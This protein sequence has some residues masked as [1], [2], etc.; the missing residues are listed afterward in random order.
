MKLLLTLA[1][2]NNQ[3][4]GEVDSDVLSHIFTTHSL[5]LSDWANR[6]KETLIKELNRTSE[7]SDRAEAIQQ[8]H[9]YFDDLEN[10]K[11]RR[12]QAATME[13]KFKEL[14]KQLSLQLLN[15]PS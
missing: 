14:T 5:A 8:I 10:I 6:S 3:V 15:H 7:I 13:E 12:A 11:R 4:F 1:S 9:Y 2:G